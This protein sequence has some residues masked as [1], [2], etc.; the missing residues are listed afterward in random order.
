MYVNEYNIEQV[1]KWINEGKINGV[2]SEKKN[3]QKYRVQMKYA[4][5]EAGTKVRYG[6]IIIR[7]ETHVD[8]FSLNGKG[9]F[10][11]KI[12]DKIMRKGSDKVEEIELTKK[13]EFKLKIGDI[14]ERQMMNGDYV[15]LNR[16]PTLHVGSMNGHRVV[17][18][19]GMTLRTNVGI[20][21]PYNLDFDGEQNCR[22]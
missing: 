11:L 17:I 13:K 15:I 6:D 20:T 14:A 3:G 22:Q 21:K 19:E 18:R 7:G 8:P 16:Q 9:D 12:G 1:K 4:L 5:Y 2:I 10:P